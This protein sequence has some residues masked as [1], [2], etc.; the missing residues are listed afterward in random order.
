MRDTEALE[1]CILVLPEERRPWFYLAYAHQVTIVAREHFL[2]ARVER[3][4]RCNETLHRLTG[5]LARLHSGEVDTATETSFVKMV[6]GGADSEGWLSLL[7]SM[8]QRVSSKES[9][10]TRP[11]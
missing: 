3:A 9:R 4:R 8:L 10:G 11:S 1:A 6:V 7:E 5:H 2:D